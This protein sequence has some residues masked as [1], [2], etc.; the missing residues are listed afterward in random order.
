MGIQPMAEAPMSAITREH[1]S[2]IIKEGNRR[3]VAIPDDFFL[4]GEEIV[5]VQDRDGVISV[6]PAEEAAREAMWARFNPFIV[7][8]DGMWPAIVEPDE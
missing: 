4:E 8:K 2:R 6:H 1:R 3:L 7:W 5:I